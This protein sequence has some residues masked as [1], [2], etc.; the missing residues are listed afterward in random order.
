MVMV[1]VMIMVMTTM[2]A[3]DLYVEVKARYQNNNVLKLKSND[4]A[5]G[6]WNMNNEERAILF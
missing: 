4:R 1:R 3:S 5:T 2:T 6:V